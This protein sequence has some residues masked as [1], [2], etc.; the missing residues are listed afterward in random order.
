MIKTNHTEIERIILAS[1]D[2]R[3]P[4]ACAY[5]PRKPV[6]CGPRKPVAC[7]RKKPTACEQTKLTS[8]FTKASFKGSNK[9]VGALNPDLDVQDV[10]EI[11]ITENKNPTQIVDLFKGRKINSKPEQ[12]IIA[13]LQEKRDAKMS[14]N[15]GKTF[16]Q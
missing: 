9:P 2:P 16:C 5:D 3:K 12:E 1:L 11:N 15:S 10:V 14:K 6:A 7:D 8:F 13:Q 4:V